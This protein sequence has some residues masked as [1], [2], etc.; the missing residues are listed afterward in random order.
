MLMHLHGA[1]EE[2]TDDTTGSFTWVDG[3]F[4]RKQKQRRIKHR[5]K[6]TITGLQYTIGVK[7]DTM[8]YPF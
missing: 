6:N 7:L 5:W 8:F 4:T 2:T 1:T 3:T